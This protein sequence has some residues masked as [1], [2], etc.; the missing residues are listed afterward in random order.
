[1]DSSSPSTQPPW[2]VPRVYVMDVCV[3]VCLRRFETNGSLTD[4]GTYLGGVVAEA[5]VSQPRLPIK[6]LPLKKEGDKVDRCLSDGD[7]QPS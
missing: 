6:V 2:L 5:V 1:M 4:V 7:L 3:S